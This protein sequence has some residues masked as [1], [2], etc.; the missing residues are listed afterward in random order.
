MAQSIDQYLQD[1]KNI[2]VQGKG[3]K[4]NE[5]A[6]GTLRSK[7]RICIPSDEN[8]KK[9]ILEEAHKSKLSIHPG[10]TKMY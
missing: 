9:L 3:T 10:A 8:L 4:F 6:D 1:M 5:G 7:N 2:V